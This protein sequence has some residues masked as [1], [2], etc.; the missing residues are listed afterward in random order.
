MRGTVAIRLEDCQT[1]AEHAVR[2]GAGSILLGSLPFIVPTERENALAI[3]CAAELPILLHNDPGRMGINMDEEFLDHV[4][5]SRNFYAIKDSSDGINHVRLLEQNSPH[6]QMSSGMDDQALEVF[7]WR[8][9]MGRRRLLEH[10]QRLLG[11]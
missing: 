8:A 9:L 6:G 11:L 2:I 1:L 7:A 5:P 10:G 3:D 4:G